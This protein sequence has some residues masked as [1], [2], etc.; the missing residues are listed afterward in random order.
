[1][2]AALAPALFGLALIGLDPST[3]TKADVSATKADEAPAVEQPLP[4]VSVR[5][6]CVAYADG[7]VGNCGVLNETRQGLGFGDAAVALMN[8]SPVGSEVQLGRATQMKFQHTIQF[9]PD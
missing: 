3:S 6:E 4:G 7:H 9:T 2:L 5:L 1:M 8:G